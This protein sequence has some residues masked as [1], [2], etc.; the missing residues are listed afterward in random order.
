MAAAAGSINR[1]DNRVGC[2]AEDDL[3]ANGQRSEDVLL[4]E[5][6][7]RKAVLQA[8]EEGSRQVLLQRD[9][10][11][12]EAKGGERNGREEKN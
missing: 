5:A 11:T 10:T 8:G 1:R 3:H 4:R 6:K 9:V 2:F 7:E 12:D